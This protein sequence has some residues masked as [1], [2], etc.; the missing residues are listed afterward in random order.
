MRLGLFR[1]LRSG[2]RP[3]TRSGGYAAYQKGRYA[4]TQ[5]ALV[6]GNDRAFSLIELIIVVVIIGI[7]AAIAIPRLSRGAAGAALSALIG[8]LAV[9]RSAIDLY[10]TEHIGSLPTL[11]DF[12]N[13]MTQYSDV[14][15]N[16]SATKSGAFIYGPYLRELP[17]LPGGPQQGRT[18]VKAPPADGLGPFGWVYSSGLIFANAA[19][20]EVDESGKPFNTY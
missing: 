4:L 18:G 15:G 16:T 12:A 1:V 3:H 13:Q 11:A 20:G 7:I 9:M 10:A 19:P 8:D 5:R 14:S 6:R 17:P 2:L